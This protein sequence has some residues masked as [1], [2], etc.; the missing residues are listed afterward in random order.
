[1]GAGI[2]CLSA[3]L[4]KDCGYEDRF[5]RRVLR[6]VVRGGRIGHVAGLFWYRL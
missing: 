5:R 6:E 1:M 4:A 2:T 3:V